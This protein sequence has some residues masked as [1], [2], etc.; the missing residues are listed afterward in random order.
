MRAWAGAVVPG[1]YVSVCG[2]TVDMNTHPGFVVVDVETSGL[3]PACARVLS[4]AAIT[5]TAC[6][7][8]EQTWHCLLNPGVDPGPIAIHGLTRARLAGQPRFA[9]VAA[10]LS[11]MLAGRT[12][13]AHNADFDY[14]F[15]EAESRR[16][17][18]ELPVAAT[19]CTVELATRLDLGV[20]RLSL[21]AL[22]HHWG[23][24]QAHPH[25]A[26]DDARVLAGVFRSALA[27]A[28]RLGVEL[29]VRRRALLRGAA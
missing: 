6:G 20:A 1:L 19:L 29:P 9:D 8:I 25:D 2:H 24:T 28:H 12:F 18:V 27:R 17:R 5:V 14:G 13:V 4:I 22:A 23:V 11:A 15:I 16:A 7:N 26:L 3:N 10:D 21:A